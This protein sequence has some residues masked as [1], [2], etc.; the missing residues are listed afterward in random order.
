MAAK[1]AKT[2]A[3]GENSAGEVEGDSALK[4]P[5]AAVK[6][7]GPQPQ[8]DRDVDSAAQLHA[9][10]NQTL[11]GRKS[12]ASPAI[13][14]PSTSAGDCRSF[15]QLL[16]GAMASPAASPHPPPILAVPIDA[17]RIPVV[18]VPCF[19][20]PAAL[21]ESHGITVCGS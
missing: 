9:P 16:A 17:P 12:A 6:L 20:A 14:V 10:A 15:L 7:E 11:A 13:A 5:A 1:E 4:E 3:S 18:A 8:S 21:L 2:D 19:L